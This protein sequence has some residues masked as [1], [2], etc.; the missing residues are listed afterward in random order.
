[1]RR[2]EPRH[3][4]IA[5][6]DDDLLAGAGARNQSGQI[7]LGLMDRYT[8]PCPDIG[9]PRA[10]AF[11]PFRLVVIRIVTRS[12]GV[13]EISFRAACDRR[14][15]RGA[16]RRD[17]DLACQIARAAAARPLQESAR[18][19]TAIPCI[20]STMAQKCILHALEDGRIHKCIYKSCHRFRDS[21]IEPDPPRPRCA[22]P[23]IEQKSSRNR[24]ETD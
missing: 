3:R 22:C 21:E 6:R 24:T 5:A 4:Q 11:W 1:L 19:L 7:R 14:P 16:V 13:V 17:T 23:Q 12:R 20:P 8:S 10:I 18:R 2:L 15:I 9:N